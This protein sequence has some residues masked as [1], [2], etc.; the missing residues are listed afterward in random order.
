[1]LKSQNICK[2]QCLLSDE[3]WDILLFLQSETKLKKQVRVI[4]GPKTRKPAEAKPW[5]YKNQG[6]KKF[7]AQSKRDPYYEARQEQK[8]ERKQAR[9]ELLLKQVNMIM[10]I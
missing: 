8:E 10:M 4:S 6:G 2:C 1:M 5:G 3:A 9:K 7:T